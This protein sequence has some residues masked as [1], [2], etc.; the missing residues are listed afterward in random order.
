MA[1]DIIISGGGNISTIE[2]EQTNL[3]Y[4]KDTPIQ[5]VGCFASLYLLYKEF[6]S[7]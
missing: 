4:T 7:D 1:K 3:D 6:V 2:V 5:G